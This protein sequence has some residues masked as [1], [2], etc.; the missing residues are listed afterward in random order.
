MTPFFGS[1]LFHTPTIACLCVL[2][3]PVCS[4]PM[5]LPLLNLASAPLQSLR[6]CGLR[7]PELGKSL[8]IGGT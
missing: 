8:L 4:R 5:L 2:P 1:V 6:Q 3:C 7:L